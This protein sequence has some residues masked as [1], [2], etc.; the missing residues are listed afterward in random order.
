MQRG[1]IPGSTFSHQLGKKLIGV[2]R[3]GRAAAR[4]C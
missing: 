1:Q 4:A 3:Q 2:M